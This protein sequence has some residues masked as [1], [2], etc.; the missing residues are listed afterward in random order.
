MDSRDLGVV[1]LGP[2]ARGQLFRDRKLRL[3]HRA[4]LVVDHSDD[5]RLSAAC[6]VSFQFT[7]ALLDGRQL[8]R[9]FGEQDR[10]KLLVMPRIKLSVLA[11]RAP[12]LRSSAVALALPVV[13]QE[14]RASA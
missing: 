6:N 14:R 5:L 8:A 11:S 2:A 10:R 9:N 1:D 3:A 12:F 4:E 7:E 13:R